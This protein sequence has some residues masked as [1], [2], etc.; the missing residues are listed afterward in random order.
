MASQQSYFQH[1]ITDVCVSQSK[2]QNNHKMTRLYRIYWN[3]VYK[4]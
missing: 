4:L 2:M 1:A 3:Y